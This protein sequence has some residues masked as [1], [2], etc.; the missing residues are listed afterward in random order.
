MEPDPKAA[1]EAARREA[2]ELQHARD[3]RV[4]MWVLAGAGVFLVVWIAV[5]LVAFLV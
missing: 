5:V 3:T 1:D 4:L 2:E